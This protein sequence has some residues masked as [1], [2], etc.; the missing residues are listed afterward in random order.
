MKKRITRH[1]IPF[2]D[3]D[4][5]PCVRVPLSDGRHFAELY[6]D[7]YA[8]LLTQGVTGNWQY[9][10]PNRISRKGQR[11][12]VQCHVPRA[13]PSRSGARCTALTVARLILG[14]PKG[15]RIYYRDNNTLNLRRDNLCLREGYAPLDREALRTIAAGVAE[16]D[17][18]RQA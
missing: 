1:P 10:V 11:G 17:H 15:R 3:P 16:A 13:T 14:A 5:T 18:G 2:N 4:G 6:A 9:A 8:G 7:D 12:Y